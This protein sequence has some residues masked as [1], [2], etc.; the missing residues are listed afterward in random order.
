MLMMPMLHGSVHNALCHYDPNYCLGA[1]ANVYHCIYATCGWKDIMKAG[2][3]FQAGAWWLGVH[4]SDYNRRYCINIIPCY[5][6]WIA[7]REGATP[8]KKSLFQ[9]S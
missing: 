9:W 8:H 2:I 4:Y 6:I 1:I 7:L 3:V 5:T